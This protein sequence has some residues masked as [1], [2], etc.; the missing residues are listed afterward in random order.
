MSAETAQ[1]DRFVRDLDT[2]IY[3]LMES[4]RLLIRKGQVGTS[5]V[6]EQLQVETASSNILLH[7]HALLEQIHDIRTQ[8]L[9]HSETPEMG[10]R[11]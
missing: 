3:K 4:Y 8:I 10:S 7:S 5:N 9:L 11:G 2:N 6:H 1:R